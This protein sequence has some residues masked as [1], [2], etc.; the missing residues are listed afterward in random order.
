VNP[1]VIVGGGL[2]G[3]AA[4]VHLSSRR[5]PVLLLEQRKFLGGRAYSFVDDSTGTVIDN[6]QH[7]LIAGYARTMEFLGTIGTRDRLRVQSAP[8]FVFHHPRRGFCSFRLPLLPT[9][10]HLL[11]GIITTDLFSAADKL[12]LLR[13]GGALRA[14]RPEA[15]GG[16]TVDAW[17]DSVGQS[18]ETKRSF[19]E[20]LA[21]AIMNE[22]IAVASALV[23]IR[24][25]RTAF[26][27]GAR[28]A[29]L[30]IP[31]VGLSD[32]YVEPARAFIERQ[33]GV[34]RCGADVTGSVV[35]GENVACV[36]LKEGEMIPCSALILAV[37][38]YRAASLLPAAL[39]ES[40]YM[41][42]AATIPLSPIVSV[43]LWFEK[44]VMPQE[45]LGVIGRRVQWVF[46]RRTIGHENGPENEKRRGGHISAV[47]SAAHA[48][49]E[50]GNDELTRIVLEDLESIYGPN[51]GRAKHAVV[52][53][54]KRA[55]FSC[56]PEVERIRP[57]CVTSVPNLFIAGDWTDTGYPA[58]IEGAI[59]SGERCAG[60]AMA[61][62]EGAK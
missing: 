48:F 14:F 25:I 61:L 24:A 23:F 6:G 32:L 19:W 27:S 30:A 56:T 62:S 18:A 37:P 1:V 53:R 38:S 47:I 17:L 20:P 49:V 28:G 57:R 59:T 5:I 46:N 26:L 54:E 11:G 4:A 13:A 45:T 29:A 50:M 10:L 43:H 8:E 40:G 41:A 36:L 21:V 33:G 35:D 44:D 3:L 55:T 51:A 60:R 34:L 2:S 12:R 7:V 58:T 22:R 42:T 9:P 31:T 15:A 39:R 52:I 16:M